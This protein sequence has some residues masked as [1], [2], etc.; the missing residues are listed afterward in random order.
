M[1]NM[2]C[3]SRL[4][5]F[6]TFAALFLTQ[7][8]CVMLASAPRIKTLP[9]LVEHFK[10]C[11]LKINKIQN[12]VYQ[13]IHASDGVVLYIE[14]AK[15]EVYRYNPEKR[16]QK[17]RLDEVTKTGHIRILTIPVKAVRNGNLIMLT[18][19]KHPKIHDIIKAFKSY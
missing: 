19:T 7:S 8:G 1:L 17:E 12:V 9:G 13:A 6:A 14:G 15:V 4:A 11:G 18:Y 16:M 5:L 3:F 2:R 10:F